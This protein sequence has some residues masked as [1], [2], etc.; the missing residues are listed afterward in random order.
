LAALGGRRGLG[1][2]VGGAL[3]WI[4][5]R[6]LWSL[7]VPRASSRPNARRFRCMAKY[8]IRHTDT[9]LEGEVGTFEN[10][11]EAVAWWF[12]YAHQHPAVQA[13]EIVLER[14]D[15]GHRWASVATHEADG[16]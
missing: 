12:D 16:T 7:P 2:I 1:G 6:P 15:G 3:L 5:R 9:D 10:D 11:G 13:G 4:R 8:R 14:D